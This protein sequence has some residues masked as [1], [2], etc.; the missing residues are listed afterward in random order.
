MFLQSDFFF[1]LYY[2]KIKCFWFV[3]VQIIW[4][5]QGLQLNETNKISLLCAAFDSKK[6]YPT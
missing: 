1:R 4:E 3:K 2:K 6:F 5:S